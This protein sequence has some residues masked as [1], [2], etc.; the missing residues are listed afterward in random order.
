MKEIYNEL[1]A[2]FE[3]YLKENQIVDEVSAIHES[4]E[5]DKKIKF[6]KSK[7]N[8]VVLGLNPSGSKKNEEINDDGFLHYMPPGL[9][10][11]EHISAFIKMKGVGRKLFYDQYFKKPHD[12][13][14]EHNYVPYWMNPVI[15]EDLI[16]EKVRIG[17]LHLN[18][19]EILERYLDIYNKH[20]YLYFNDLIPIRITNSWHLKHYFKTIN[21]SLKESFIKERISYLI[22][23]YNPKLILI[24]NAFV[25]DLISNTRFEKEYNGITY[26]IINNETTVVFSSIMSNG[27]LDKYSEQRLKNEVKLL[28]LNMD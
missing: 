26:K 27:N 7:N 25:S 23:V 10:L 9:I 13:F 4:D 1:T 8:I 14:F 11:D 3:N 19:G 20:R 12:L 22:S 15:G 16:K 18:E 21:N 6:S 28:L 24:N 2:D 17:R 5:F